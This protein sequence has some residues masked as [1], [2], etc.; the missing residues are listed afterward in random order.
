MLGDIANFIVNTTT[1]VEGYW[2][3]YAIPIYGM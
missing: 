1:I 2:T 3:D